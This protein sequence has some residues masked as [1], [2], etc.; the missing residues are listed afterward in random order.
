MADTNLDL[1]KLQESIDQLSESLGS[2][3][4]VSAQASSAGTAMAGLT[5]TANSSSGAERA[6]AK[7]LEAASAQTRAGLSALAKAAGAAGA[8]MYNGQKG[9]SAFNDT[10]DQGANALKAFGAALMLLG[11]PIGLVAGGLM[12]L[13]GSGAKLVKTINQQS[14][15]VYKGFQDLSRSGGAASD[16]MSGLFADVQK[17]GL[18]FQDLGTL[19]ALVGES[20]KDLA[21]FGGSV[22]QGRKQFADMGQAMAPFRESLFNAGMTQE[23]INAASMGYLR[24]QTRIGQ[25][26]NKTADELANGAR[27]YLIEQD[28]LTKLTG[29]TRKEQEDAREEIRSQERFAAVL[30]E[31]RAKGQN[32]AAQ[33][34]EDSYLILKSQSKEAAQGFAD[35]STGMLTTE[36]AQKSYLATQGESMRTAERIKAG[37]LTAAQGAQRVAAA[38]GANADAM[39]ASLG[40]MGVYN[41]TFGDLAADLRLKGMSEGDIEE[42]LKKI[43]QDQIDQGVTGKKAADGAQQAQTDMRISQQKSMLALQAM[44]DKGVEPVTSVMASLAKVVEH[45]TLGLTKLLN[46]LGMGPAKEKTKEEKQTD[47][48]LEKRKRE[49]L[50]AEWKVVNAKGEYDKKIAAAELKAA[51]S[52]LDDAEAAQKYTKNRASG[53]TI[54]SNAGAEEF[55]GAGATIVGA[56]EDVAP[57]IKRGLAAAGVGAAASKSAPSGSGMS[58]KGLA[59]AGLQLRPSGGDIQQEGAAVS[60]KLIELAKKIQGSVE[61]FNY[62]S[63]FNDQY[64]NEKSPSS[65][66]TKGLALDFVLNRKP[67]VEEGQKIASAIQALGAGKVIDEYNA[68]SAKATGGHMHVSIPEFEMG[69]IATGPKSGY[70]ATLH[71]EEAVIPLKNGAV[72]VSLDMKNIMQPEGIGPTFSGFNEYTGYNKGPMT[73]DLAAI[74]S[75]AAKLGAYDAATKMITD[76]TTWKQILS[77]GIATNYN[78]GMAEIGTKMLPGIGADIGERIQELKSTGGADTAAAIKQVAGEFKTAMLEAVQKMGGGDTAVAADQLSALTQL[79]QEQRNSNSIQEKLLRAAAS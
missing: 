41:Q 37:E 45:V 33:E 64:H 19:T 13:V 17:L 27:K 67:S 61:G 15:A 10:I 29:M 38:H 21:L 23:E 65:Q 68:P 9:A 73:T 31:M 54:P 52:K 2:L 58:Q 36:A 34:L 62:F 66:H 75:I 77:S 46:M 20:S 50:D 8:A 74:K 55:G 71:G 48:A 56:D 60:P 12:M 78:L 42:K 6:K 25:T 18:G 47:E 39:G 3:S 49:V 16:G 22:S 7:V 70:P 14:D 35:V 76:P 44:I 4:G 43:K 79:V 69:G 63:G 59:D 1:A 5:T 51:K 11:G 32:A 40:K 53:K 30:M 57:G 26:Q 24:L 72:P 28:A